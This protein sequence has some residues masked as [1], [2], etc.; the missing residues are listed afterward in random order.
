VPVIRKQAS[1]R[2]Q[3]RWVA[4]NDPATPIPVTHTSFGITT[5]FRTGMPR[6]A[7]FALSLFAAEPSAAPDRASSCVSGHFAPGCLGQ[8]SRPGVAGDAM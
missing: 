5:Y 2:G 6:G 7:A 8:V 4:R 3:V 1:G